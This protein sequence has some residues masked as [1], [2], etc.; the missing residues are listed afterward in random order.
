MKINDY[1]FNNICK[2][3]PI[4]YIAKVNKILPDFISAQ[5]MLTKFRYVYKYIARC[6]AHLIIHGFCIL[7]IQMSPLSNITFWN[8]STLVHFQK[9]LFCIFILY[10]HLFN[11]DKRI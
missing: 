1:L 8:N 6:M 2:I 10:M 4:S 5:L 11:W 3:I 9:I 7:S